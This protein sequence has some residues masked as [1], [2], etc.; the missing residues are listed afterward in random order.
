MKPLRL[1]NAALNAECSSECWMSLFGL[2]RERGALY[3]KQGLPPVSRTCG[4]NS[5]VFSKGLKREL[6]GMLIFVFVKSLFWK[7]NMH[8]EGTKSENFCQFWGWGV[9]GSRLDR[10]SC[11]L[12]AC[13][14]FC[15]FLYTRIFGLTIPIPPPF[16]TLFHLS[17]LYLRTIF[18]R[19]SPS[20]PIHWFSMQCDW[21][22]WMIDSKCYMKKVLHKESE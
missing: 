8:E 21:T 7:W 16:F 14:A 19:A 2:W 1:L 3:T 15:L 17:A 13:S 5:W 12:S 6:R 11:F 18:L 9:G 22:V 10:G 4:T 20:Q